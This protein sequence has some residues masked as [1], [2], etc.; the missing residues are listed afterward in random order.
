MLYYLQ[1]GRFHKVNMIM[2]DNPTQ[3]RQY[4]LQG[5]LLGLLPLEI[6][7]VYADNPY[8]TVAQ[9]A[10]YVQRTVR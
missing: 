5:F 4:A 7:T 2:T 3:F 10:C 6:L 9:A 1:H 8:L